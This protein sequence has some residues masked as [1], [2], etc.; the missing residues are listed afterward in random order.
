[1]VEAAHLASEYAE[2]KL[3]ITGASPQDEALR[4]GTGFGHGRLVIEP[5]AKTTF[6]N[7]IYSRQLVAP[8]RNEKWLIVTSAIHMPRAIGAFREAG[9]SVLPWPVADRSDNRTTLHEVFGLLGYWLLG[10]I[11]SPF[12]APGL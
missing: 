7:A 6:E 2:A 3:V 12:P 11:D 9:F 10:R 8:N 1:M 4:A 5:K